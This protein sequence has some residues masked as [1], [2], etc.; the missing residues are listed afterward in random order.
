MY[1]HTQPHK[2]NKSELVNY[3]LLNKAWA[4]KHKIKFDT[5]YSVP[6]HHSGVFPVHDQL[7]ETWKKIWKIQAT[8]TE[9][10][11]H[12]KPSRFRRGFV[13]SRVKG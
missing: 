13:Y 8:S 11:P 1:K 7:Y 9:E 2:L 12:L 4:D 3:M 5:F 6:P 10:Y